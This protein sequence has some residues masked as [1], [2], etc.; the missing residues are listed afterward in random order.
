MFLFQY[1][2][3]L[4]FLYVN[5]MYI[6]TNIYNIKEEKVY[7]IKESVHMHLKQKRKTKQ[8]QA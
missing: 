6:S 1:L 8:K 3:L 7:V 5:A 2:H 4:Y